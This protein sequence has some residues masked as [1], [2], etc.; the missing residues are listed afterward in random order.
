MEIVGKIEKI[1]NKGDRYML[2]IE[3]FKHWFFTKNKIDYEPNTNVKIIYNIN[4]KGNDEFHNIEKIEKINE[5]KI[6]KINK[7]TWN[8]KSNTEIMKERAK[9]I[10][11]A[12]PEIADIISEMKKKNIPVSEQTTSTLLGILVIGVRE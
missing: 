2:K 1:V 6:E 9:L 12:V 8:K 10:K 5:E 3:N 4:K 11:E 7:S